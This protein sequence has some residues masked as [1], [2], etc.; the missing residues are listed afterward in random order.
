MAALNRAGD[1]LELLGFQS[2]DGAPQRLEALAL[3]IAAR[4]LLD[5]AAALLSGLELVELLELAPKPL[6]KG[7]EAT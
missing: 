5:L 3:P 1:A 6:D 2:P 7:F 4:V